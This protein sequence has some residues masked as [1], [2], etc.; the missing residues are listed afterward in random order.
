MIRPLLLWMTALA[1]TAAT[2]ATPV[3][4]N[5]HIH[6]P[7]GTRLVEIRYDLAGEQGRTYTVVIEF[8]ADG[9]QSFAA[10]TGLT[11]V[12]GAGI[13]P[14]PG[15]QAQWDAREDWAAAYF[16]AVQA[17]V[18]AMEEEFQGSLIA[19]YPFDGNA[20]DQ[21]GKGNHGLN[22]G[23]VPTIDRNGKPGSAYLFENDGY[24]IVDPPVLNRN[25]S[26][27]IAVW[28]LPNAIT[29]NQ[30]IVMERAFDGLDACG[31]FS[32]GNFDLG[33]Y[34]GRFAFTTAT[35]GDS[36]LQ[37]R[38]F[39]DVPIVPGVWYFI[40]ASYDRSSGMM[41]LYLNGRLEASE[42]VFTNLRTHPNAVTRI[43]RNSNLFLGSWVGRIDDLRIFDVSLGQSAIMQLFNL[44]DE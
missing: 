12:V 5:V 21:S 4:S 3:V 2:L 18:T 20:N 11:G 6:Q 30:S 31:R 40:A 39:S 1:T 33:V 7:E 22:S 13:A 41:N 44:S 15:K 28:V 34:E 38:I 23:A 37:N 17:R 8:S 36:C 14:G 43:G 35:Y 16:P 26:F 9:G 24:I 25:S 32:A 10:V 29:N 27:T 19:F 42:V